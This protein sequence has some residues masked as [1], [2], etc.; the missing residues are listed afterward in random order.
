VLLPCGVKSTAG[1]S[2]FYSNL[3]VPGDR[4]NSM[5]AASGFYLCGSGSP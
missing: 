3:A 1:L 5:P 2:A 4:L